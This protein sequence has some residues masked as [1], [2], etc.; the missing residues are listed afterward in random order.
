LHNKDIS[1]IGQ[2]KKIEYVKDIKKVFNNINERIEKYNESEN[3]RF[4]PQFDYIHFDQLIVK[5]IKLSNNLGV[6]DYF[7][8]GRKGSG[9]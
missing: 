6:K 3:K 4:G 9:K 5:I 2:G 1:S 8:S 7:L